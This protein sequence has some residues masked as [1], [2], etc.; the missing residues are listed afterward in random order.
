MPVTEVP[1]EMIERFGQATHETIVNGEIPFRKAYLPSVIDRIEVDDHVV[2][3]NTAT[4]EQVVAGKCVPAAGVHCLIRNWRA[5]RN[6]A[7]N[8]SIAAG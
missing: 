2:V 8:S 7:M 3:G 1:P 6:K 5:V 4:L